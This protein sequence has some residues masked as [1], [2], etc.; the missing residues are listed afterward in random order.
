MGI[1]IIMV[2]I[3]IKNNTSILIIKKPIQALLLD[4]LISLGAQTVV[5]IDLLASALGKKMQLVCIFPVDWID[6]FGVTESQVNSSQLGVE[7]G[8]IFL[9]M[10]F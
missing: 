5:A 10:S 7:G 2:I 1:L 3:I 4:Y 8:L 9:T 6:F